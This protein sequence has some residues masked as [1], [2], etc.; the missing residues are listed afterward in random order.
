MQYRFKNF[1]GVYILCLHFAIVLCLI[2]FRLTGDYTQ[3]S[4]STLLGITLPMFGGFAAA[5][6]RFFIANRVP[7][8]VNPDEKP[9]SSIFKTLVC[10]LPGIFAAIVIFSIVAQAQKKVFSDFENAKAFIL[11]VESIFAVACGLL[12]YAIFEKQQ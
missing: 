3:E 12:I 9:F 4:F 10:L 7:P 8:L 2:T 6:I 11:S 1:L 5:I